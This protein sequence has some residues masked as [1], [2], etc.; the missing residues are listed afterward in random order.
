MSLRIFP[1]TTSSFDSVF[2]DRFSRIDRL[3]SQLTG[4]SPVSLTP[5]YNLRQINKELFELM[6]S[7]PGWKEHELQIE[8]AGGRL[9]ISGCKD[10]GSDNAAD[11]ASS[12]A[13]DSGW[14]HRGIQRADFSLSFT[15]PEHMKVTAAKL[16]DGLLLVDLQMEIPESEKPKRIPI[17]H[18]TTGAI[19]YQA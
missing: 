1:V 9:T 18:R 4:D 13:S 14:L 10:K 15:V 5:S 17:E 7:V 16:E 6:V 2:S 11:N 8:T 3:F 12:G 19:E